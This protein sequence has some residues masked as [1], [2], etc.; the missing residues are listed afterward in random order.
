MNYWEK[1]SF[2]ARDFL[3]GVWGLLPVLATDGRGERQ[4]EMAAQEDGIAAFLWSPSSTQP[5]ERPRA[6]ADAGTVAAVGRGGGGGGGGGGDRRGSL[7]SS[8]TASL[9]TPHG[10]APSRSSSSG[11]HAGTP[12][13]ST[14]HR[15]PLSNSSAATPH[16]SSGGGGGGGGG[17]AMRRQATHIR[18]EEMEAIVGGLTGQLRDLEGER[19]REG[20]RRAELVFEVMDTR[21]RASTIKGQLKRLQVRKM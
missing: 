5:P 2:Y 21:R 17:S 3:N 10:H 18:P 15:P 7:Q 13:E 11:R 1:P 19:A 9:R 6:T 4:A 20:R 8:S 16:P 14:P 12:S